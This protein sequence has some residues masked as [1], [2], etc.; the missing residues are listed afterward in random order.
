[1]DGNIFIFGIICA[2][3]LLLLGQLTKWIPQ[4]TYWAID[5]FEKRRKERG[6][7]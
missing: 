5:Q 7:T 6:D 3:V 2:A 1:M 4:F